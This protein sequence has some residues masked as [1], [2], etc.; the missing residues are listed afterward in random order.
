MKG[1]NYSGKCPDT[2][3]LFSLISFLISGLQDN[4]EKEGEV[5]YCVTSLFLELGS[6]ISPSTVGS[7]SEHS[8]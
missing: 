1:T 4:Q 2:I 8:C 7:C 5:A 6:V 3:F